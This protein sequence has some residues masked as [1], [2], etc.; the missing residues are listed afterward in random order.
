MAANTSHVKA[1]LDQTLLVKILPADPDNRA[2]GQ[3]SRLVYRA[4]NKI[5]H[6]VVLIPFIFRSRNLTRRAVVLPTSAHS[7]QNPPRTRSPTQ[8]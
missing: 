6:E 4:P 2:R 5:R 3:A 1:L 7:G 8:D